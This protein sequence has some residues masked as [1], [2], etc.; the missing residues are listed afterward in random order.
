M[1]YAFIACIVVLI[2][3][4]VMLIV[5]MTGDTE[6]VWKV[7]IKDGLKYMNLIV[8]LFVVVVP[9]GLPLTIGVSLAYSTGRMYQ[10]DRILVKELDAPEKMGEVNEIIVG[11]T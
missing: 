7:I 6:A 3:L 1:K 11:K 5:K 10:E 9:E 4:I 2:L 8:V